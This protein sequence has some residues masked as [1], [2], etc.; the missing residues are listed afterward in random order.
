MLYIGKRAVKNGGGTTTGAEC[1]KK[2]QLSAQSRINAVLHTYHTTLLS[3]PRQHSG[4]QLT[5]RHITVQCMRLINQL[6]LPY[7][8]CWMALPHPELLE[9]QAANNQQKGW[10]KGGRP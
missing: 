9:L 5:S 3:S 6:Q 1:I 4:Q 2:K 7:S 8:L 10:P